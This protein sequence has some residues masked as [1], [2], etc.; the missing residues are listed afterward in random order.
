MQCE[1]LIEGLIG[2]GELVILAA[3]PKA[4]KTAI[5]SA[6]ALAIA[7]GTPFG[8]TP[9][10]KGAVLWLSLEESPSERAAIM[11]AAKGRPR[12]PLYTVFEDMRPD[13]PQ[14]IARLRH[15]CLL[16]EPMLIV[17]DPLYAAQS[18]RSNSQTLEALAD[19]AHET[20]AAVLVLHHLRAWQK[21]MEVADFM[22]YATA[23]WSL[24]NRQLRRYRIV[25]LRRE[26]RTWVPRSGLQQG[27]PCSTENVCRGLGIDTSHQPEAKVP[28]SPMPRP[29]TLTYLSKKPLHY[30][31]MPE[32]NPFTCTSEILSMLRDYAF[33][34]SRQIATH[35]GITHGATR[36][37]I[38]DLKQRGAILI[39]HRSSRT[40]YYKLGG[41]E[42]H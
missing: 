4:G 1:N 8:S 21:H 23:V 15:L 2:A 5:A 25:T 17:I 34:S 31:P 9:T 35:L 13:T 16:Y 40:T 19:I 32:S 14:G 18:T 6:M 29:T 26:S 30:K 42:T 41:T 12:T 38:A 39:H 20:G 3:P 11:H 22:R 7:K 28:K 24:D 10:D 27:I 33:L 37:Q 36:N